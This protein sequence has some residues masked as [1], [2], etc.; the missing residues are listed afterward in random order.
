[1]IVM[2]AVII[3]SVLFGSRRSL[4]A[5][6][7]RVE[8]AFLNGVE[9]DGFSI[10][11]DLNIRVGES[12]NLITIAK[13]YLDGNDPA[14]R[15]VQEA[16]DRLN[17][18]DDPSDMFD[19]NQRLTEACTALSDKLAGLPLSEKDEKYRLGIVDE[20]KS[21]NDTISHDGYNDLAEKFNA[22]LESFPA[23]ILSRL[24]GVKPISLFQ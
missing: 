22:R 14:I 20:L 17:E 24:T 18:S 19:A 7:S 8:S 13:R 12:L 21:R 11:N 15:A 6:R 10:G 1:M 23:N 2:I 4:Y 5:E 3:F 16:C 9:G